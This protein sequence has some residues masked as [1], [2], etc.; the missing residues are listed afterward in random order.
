VEDGLEG[1]ATVRLLQEGRLVE[2][3]RGLDYK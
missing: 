3:V 2:T 1:E